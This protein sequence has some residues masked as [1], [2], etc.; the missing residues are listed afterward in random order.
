MYPKRNLSERFQRIDFSKSTVPSIIEKPTVVSEDVQRYSGKDF[1]I[2][3][4]VVVEVMAEL[5]EAT[6]GPRSLDKMIIGSDGIIWVTH[7][8]G[9]I[10]S[11]LE[12]DHPI[13]KLMVSLV[14]TVEKE[15]G[16]GR[17]TAVILAA[18]LLMK[19]RKLIE[20]GFSP[21]EII[22]GY[23]QAGDKAL[24]A[25]RSLAKKLDTANKLALE[26][27]VSI[28]FPNGDKKIIEICTET[29]LILKE[30]SNLGFDLSDVRF[31]QM[32][33]GSIDDSQLVKGFVIRRELADESMPKKAVNAAI[34]ILKGELKDKRRGH[35]DYEHRLLFENPR[36]LEEFRIE[37]IALFRELVTRI[38]SIGATVVI[39]EQGIDPVVAKIF[40]DEE[41]M[42]IRR[43][44]VE[45]LDR[46]A[47]ATGA[48][49]VYDVNDISSGCLGFAKYV[50]IRKHQGLEWLFIDGCT[51][52]W[53]LTILLRGASERLLNEWESG[54]KNALVILNAVFKKP[55]ILSGGGAADIEVSRMLIDES[56][57][58]NGRMLHVVRCFAESLERP[59]TTLVKNAGMDPLEVIPT[60]KA[61]HSIGG[62]DVGFDGLKG[63]I[64]D[65][66][67][68][69]IFDLLIEKEV[70]IHVVLEAVSMILRIDD[71]IKSRTLE[72][73]AKAE[74]MIEVA[75]SKDY[76]KK[77]YRDHRLETAEP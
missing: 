49:I 46:I 5:I 40:A 27:L 42:V 44:V 16:S 20:L 12:F 6:F 24:E 50:E 36:Q 59:I 64:G 11:K 68:L 73:K 19:S 58:M 66:T 75:R 61:K 34:L 31:T 55:Q 1:R 29:A 7:N 8:C 14:N 45:D 51:D 25:Y 13:A 71:Y 23:I 77:L 18:E 41:I 65:M 52:P 72:G 28:V 63:K 69:R 56:R 47:K 62:R 2:N 43:F 60:I 39:L 32:K 38:K 4:I 26:E 37:R 9:T 17:K 30:K 21:H 67:S 22:E 15:V 10:F 33:G 3:N 35:T 57:G 48:K 70:I 53:S 54:A 74:K 76:K